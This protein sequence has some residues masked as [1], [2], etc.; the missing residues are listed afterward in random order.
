MDASITVSGI[1]MTCK[2]LEYMNMQMA[3]VTL[4]NTTKTRKKDSAF[5]N[6][7]MAVIMK[8]GGQLANNTV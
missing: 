6:G 3:S 2:E 4:D 8:A 1:K 7:Q 5:I